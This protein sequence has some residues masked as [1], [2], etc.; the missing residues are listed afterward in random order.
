MLRRGGIT[1]LPGTTPSEDQYGELIPEI[2]RMM[3]RLS[4][5]GHKIFAENIDRYT[6]TA[7]QQKYLLGPS[8]QS[9]GA[10]LPVPVPGFDADYPLYIDRAN[11]VIAGSSPEIH[12]SLKILSD[13]DWAAKTITNLQAAY[14]WEI[15]SDGAAPN[16]MLY[17]Y[18]IPGAAHDLELF[19]WQ[20][21]QS[22][23]TSEDNVVVMP[24]GYEDA[25]VLAGALRVRRLYPYDSKLTGLQAQELQNDADRA[26]RALQIY[27]AQISPYKN[28][29]ANI[30]SG[31]GGAGTTAAARL[32]GGIV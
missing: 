3:S 12:R 8:A 6:L 9:A 10:A 5:D 21:L 14:P 18:G 15:Y 17:L 26:V 23:F 24:P 1:Q 19:T 30:N 7:G 22:G 16:S 20:Q 2:N 4:L 11:I 27:N 28:D 13:K 25:M 29:A 32:Q 31:D